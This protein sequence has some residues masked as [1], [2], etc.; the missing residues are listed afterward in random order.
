[1]NIAAL[2]QQMLVLFSVL[3]V[4]FF[5]TKVG[6]LPAGTG[7]YLSELVVGVT[8]PATTLYAVATS[9]RALSNGDVAMVLL[10]TAL[11]Y[12]ALILLATLC[13]R[14]FRVP[15]AQAGVYRFLLVFANV[16][17]LGYPVVQALSG[18]DAVFIASMY[19]LVFQ[20]LCFTYGV[21]QVSGKREKFSWR[22]LARPMI[23]ASTLSLVLY[24]T[25]FRFPPM[26][27][28][29]L[30]CLDQITAP[31][32]MLVI[33]CTLAACSF[34]ELFT[35]WRVYVWCLLKLIVIPVLTWAV[36][37]LF[38]TDGLILL[39]MVVLSALPSATNSVLLCVKYGG[40][41]S[42]AASGVFLS[43]MLSIV[44]LPVLLQI[45]F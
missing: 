45:L 41:E 2:N 4:G 23:V 14:L 13:T 8:C 37:R 31:A 6:L 17:F 19:N 28:K 34:R 1:M 43:T 22:I 9:C 25:A 38:V 12:G 21:A 30:G 44:T 35:K 32:S 10:I 29:V 33:G 16:G 27:T 3:F 11:I 24:L 7:K 36:L 26:V 39:V 40:D 15:R 18:P 5:A 42:T 20:L